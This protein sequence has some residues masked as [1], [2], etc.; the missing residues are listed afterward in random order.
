M[1]I[2]TGLALRPEFRKQHDE[3]KESARG[4]SPAPAPSKSGTEQGDPNQPKASD[5]SDQDCMGMLPMIVLMIVVFYFFLIR[6]QQKQEKTLKS[7][8]STLKKGDRVVT[9][10][11][12]HA[13]VHS[14]ETNA[15]T[16]KLL[17]EEELGGVKS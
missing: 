1:I 2:P 7:M 14:V 17:M 3:G 8:R 10:G 9:S 5:Q 6:P 12:M 15:V 11:G 16:Q 13:V 4:G